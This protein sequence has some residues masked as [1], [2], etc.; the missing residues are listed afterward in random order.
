M[1][2]IYQDKPIL[3]S[4]LNFKTDK[5]KLIIQYINKYKPFKDTYSSDD[6]L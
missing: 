2:F 3:I 4:F 5:K 1:T 6:F